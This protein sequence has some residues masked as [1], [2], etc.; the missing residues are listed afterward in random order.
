MYCIVTL[1][2]TAQVD[3]DE[4]TIQIPLPNVDYNIGKLR[5]LINNILY[6][7][8]ITV[9]DIQLITYDQQQKQKLSNQ[10]STFEAYITTSYSLSQLRSVIQESLDD[11][12]DSWMEGDITANGF[13]IYRN[14]ICLSLY[15]YYY[16]DIQLVDIQPITGSLAVKPTIK[17]DQKLPP[18]IKPIIITEPILLI[19][20]YSHCDWDLLNYT[21]T[22]TITPST[23]KQAPFANSIMSLLDSCDIYQIASYYSYIKIVL[24][25][26][27][28]ININISNTS[29]LYQWFLDQL[30]LKP[31]SIIISQPFNIDLHDWTN[32]T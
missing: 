1:N 15:D 18:Q 19:L 5:S 10:T 12:G 7:E 32:C 23:Y 28:N 31:E 14:N 6:D 17:L 8:D 2:I 22:S 16:D 20:N 25:I 24:K 27:I 13:I 3:E 11:G 26:N 29:D 21:N 4:P 30:E 9:H